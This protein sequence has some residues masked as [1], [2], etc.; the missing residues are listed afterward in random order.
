[1]SANP[2]PAL[3][4]L[5]SFLFPGLGQ[6]YAG[7]LRKAVLWALPMLVFILAIIWLLLGPKIGLVGLITNPQTRVALL[8]LNLAFF[9]Y[10]VAAMVD[11]YSVAKAVRG[12]GFGWSSSGAAPIA[13]AALVAV[14]M[15]L[16]GVPEVIGVDVN[17][18][19]NVIGQG[20]PD[21]IPSFT[22][23][24]TQVATIPP[25]TTP[26]PVESATASPDT[27]DEPT[28]EPTPSGPVGPTPTPLPCPQANYAGWEPAADG[29][30]NILLSG[31]DSRSD[32]G[33]GTTSIRTDSMMLLSIDI[34]SC[35]AAL[36][37]F[38]RNMNCDARYP[39]WFHIPLENGQDFP[40]CLNALWRDA[41]SHPANYPGSEGIGPDCQMQFD[42]VRGW[43][44]LTSAI[45]SFANEQVD[46]V[47]SVNLKGFVALVNAL[48][49]HGVWIDVP[50]PG[51]QDLPG[52]CPAPNQD[53][54]C[55][56]R[57]SQ[58]QPMV[59][60]FAPGCQFLHGEEALAFARSRH[61]DSDYWR[62]RRQQ[63]F[64]QQVR[65]QIDPL[66]LLTNINDL[67][68]AAEQNLFMT[69]QQSDFQNLAQIAS[70]VDA[71]RLY[72]YDFAPQKL[73]AVGSMD[74]MA[75]KIQNIFS[76]PLPAPDNQNQD[77]C[78]PR[79]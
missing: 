55:Q 74:G 24:P 26:S 48:P 41:A 14:T 3:G 13:L 62:A 64:L 68:A 6:F 65:R 36:F 75:A 10:H 15:V 19:L 21:V 11:A 47:V 35:K 69:F 27:S 76:E 17:T 49:G 8:V 33:V 78:P 73:E 4:A 53:K 28:D 25:S 7:D 20:H 57:D 45:Q 52:P 9:L 34:A 37:S 63:I 72:R 44:A 50:K 77:P 58:Q 46:G 54:I 66:A 56:Y 23:R 38:P 61:Q 40:D 60:N 70:H 16:H 42:C 1:M 59:V 12:Y 79:N 2:S 71:D 51:L 32:T 67:L 18:A 29:K 31:S 5:L 39:T 22:P 43:R 30:L